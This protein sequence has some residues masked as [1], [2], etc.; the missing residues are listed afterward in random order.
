MIEQ[1]FDDV[2]ESMYTKNYISVI[3]ND[4]EVRIPNWFLREKGCLSA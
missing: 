2:I 3:V 1:N 4:V